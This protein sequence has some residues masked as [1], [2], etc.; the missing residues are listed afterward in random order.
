M[1][2]QDF[3]WLVFNAVLGGILSLPTLITLLF[4]RDRVAVRP[5]DQSYLRC[6][7]AMPP[8]ATLCLSCGFDQGG[9]RSSAQNAVGGM[10]R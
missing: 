3:A 7:E 2:D 1:S 8:G 4:R 6:A 10:V 9:R 5:L